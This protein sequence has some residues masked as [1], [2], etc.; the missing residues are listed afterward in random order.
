[1]K[2]TVENCSLIKTNLESG[3]GKPNQT[4]LGCAGYERRGKLHQTCKDCLL[5]ECNHDKTRKARKG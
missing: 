3:R 1:M 2:R 5:C 4:T